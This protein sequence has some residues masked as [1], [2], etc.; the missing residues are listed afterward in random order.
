VVAFYR[1]QTIGFENNIIQTG[2]LLLANYD[3][4]K[5]D[6]SKLNNRKVK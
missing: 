6:S 5:E 1:F 4:L 3:L 2:K